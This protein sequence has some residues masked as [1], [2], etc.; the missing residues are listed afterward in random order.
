MSVRLARNKA[1]NARVP[2]D[3]A[4]EALAAEISNHSALVEALGDNR[5]A[6]QRA[7]EARWEAYRK[8]DAAAKELEI[9][10]ISDAEAV[11]AGKPTG[12]VKTAR[13]ALQDAED[14]LQSCKDAR[15]LFEQQNR[16][17]T[18][19]VSIAD[20]N[21][22]AAVSKVVYSDPVT[23]ELCEQF[24]AARQRFQELYGA[25]SVLGLPDVRN[26]Q[27]WVATGLP[28]HARFWNSDPA[29]LFQDLPPSATAAR[30]KAWVERLRTDAYAV[31]DE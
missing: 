2:R 7:E 8:V 30:V 1:N 24:D 14:Q 16:D 31:L 21:V 4:R 28:A 27:A 9:G 13:I 17:M 10:K 11:A 26:D 25:M 3:P 5:E 19:R 6:T 15:V 18:Q 12:A 22:T 20:S 29:Y 23:R